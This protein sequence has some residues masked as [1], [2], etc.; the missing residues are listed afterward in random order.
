MLIVPHTLDASGGGCESGVRCFC[1]LAFACP[2]SCVCRF[3]C[4]YINI[5]VTRVKSQEAQTPNNLLYSPRA[6]AARAGVRGVRA[7]TRDREA[8]RARKKERRGGERRVYCRVC[9][10]YYSSHG[11]TTTTVKYHRRYHP[12]ELPPKVK[13][14]R[15]VTDGKQIHRHGSR[16]IRDTHAPVA[17]ARPPARSLG[18]FCALA[19]LLL[20]LLVLNLLGGTKEG[21]QLVPQRL[22]LIPLAWYVEP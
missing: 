19:L 17:P 6:R 21:G 2:V 11:L 13:A 14:Y 3:V 5:S 1:V 15:T 22:A 8:V 9:A 20:G 7:Q 4:E 18:S 16:A 10:S 12:T